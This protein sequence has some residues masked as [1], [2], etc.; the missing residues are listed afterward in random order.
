MLVAAYAS[1]TGML[2]LDSLVAAMR[3]S[4][5]SYRRQH[6]ETNERALTAGFGALGKGVAP[7]WVEEPGEGAVA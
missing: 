2:G 6:L 4:V 3:D 7:A 1:L 5:P